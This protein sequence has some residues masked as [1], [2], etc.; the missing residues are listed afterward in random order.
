MPITTAS[1]FSS[2]RKPT[3]CRTTSLAWA[4]FGT[5]AAASSDPASFQRMYASLI[6]NRAAYR[7]KGNI[8]RGVWQGDGRAATELITS[9]DTKEAPYADIDSVPDG[10]RAGCADFCAVQTTI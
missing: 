2:S 5:A 9:M 1:S 6:G 4:G 3:S 8:P 7:V 10:G